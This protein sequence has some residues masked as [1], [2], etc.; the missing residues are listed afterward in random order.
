MDCV[1]ADAGCAGRGP[2][3]SSDPHPSAWGADRSGVPSRG[4]RFRRG[5]G[6]GRAGSDPGRSIRARGG[7]GL[8]L[9]GH[10]AGRRSSSRGGQR[11][12]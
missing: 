8:R 12:L 5:A 7:G 3:G 2:F 1:L 11:Y 9:D 10:Q 4:V 6:R